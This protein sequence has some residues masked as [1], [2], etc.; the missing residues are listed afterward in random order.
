MWC[1]NKKVYNERE[2]KLM[3]TMQLFVRFAIISFD[4]KRFFSSYIVVIRN[5]I[6]ISMNCNWNENQTETKREKKKNQNYTIIDTIRTAI[7][8]HNKLMLRNEFVY[9]IG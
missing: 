6:A 7:N 2:N 5:K 9:A 1:A 4:W 3:K 8:F